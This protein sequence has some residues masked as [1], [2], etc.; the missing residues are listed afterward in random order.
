M[1]KKFFRKILKMFDNWFKDIN[2]KNLS[3]ISKILKMF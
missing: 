1:I 3:K 2:F